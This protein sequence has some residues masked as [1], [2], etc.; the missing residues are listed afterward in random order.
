MN[1]Q[2]SFPQ[3]LKAVFKIIGTLLK[4]I[5]TGPLGIILFMAS[6]YMAYEQ[7]VQISRF[8]EYGVFPTPYII[9]QLCLISFAL[10]ASML[11]L[12]FTFSRKLAKISYKSVVMVMLISVVVTAVCGMV[13][14]EYTSDFRY[15]YY[16]PYILDWPTQTVSGTIDCDYT[17]DVIYLAGDFNVSSNGF[18]QK[19][20][21]E[22]RKTERLSDSYKVEIHYKGKQAELF[23][24]HSQWEMEDNGRYLDRINIWPEDYDYEVPPQDIAYMYKNRVNLEYSEPLVIENIIIYTA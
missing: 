8:M 14:D 15:C 13:D 9:G 6:G 20:C 11:L 7:L 18:R 21:L 4:V 22:L 16:P 3:L 19:D 24:D 17:Q 10:G 2:K 23:I 1:S 12:R 5:Y